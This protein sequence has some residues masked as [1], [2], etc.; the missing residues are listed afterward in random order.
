MSPTLMSETFMS[1]FKFPS[2]YCCYCQQDRALEFICRVL[3]VDVSRLIANV[4]PWFRFLQGAHEQR[5]KACMSFMMQ[6]ADVRWAAAGPWPYWRLKVN[7]RQPRAHRPARTPVS[8]TAQS[9]HSSKSQPAQDTAHSPSKSNNV[10]TADLHCQSPQLSR[11]TLKYQGTPTEAG[12]AKRS[13]QSSSGRTP[14]STA[15]GSAAVNSGGNNAGSSGGQKSEV[16]PPTANSSS[17]DGAGQNAHRAVLITAKRFQRSAVAAPFRPSA[18]HFMPDGQPVC[19]YDWKHQPHRRRY[20]PPRQARWRRRQQSHQQL[21]MQPQHVPY[22]QP[23]QTK[24]SRTSRAC[25]RSR[26]PTGTQ[27]SSLCQPE[28]PT[29]SQ[30]QPRMQPEQEEFRQP[31]QFPQ[32][33]EQRFL[34]QN[35]PHMQPQQEAY[36]RPE[37]SLLQPELIA[38]L[39]KQQCMQPQQETYWQPDHFP[40]QAEQTTLPQNRQC[41]Q[42]QKVHRQQQRKQ[43]RPKGV[44]HSMGGWW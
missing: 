42:P 23:E 21:I 37:Q 16:H 29:F 13:G 36:W 11:D 20:R 14:Q 30:N 17:K 25:E 32:Q 44:Q 41:M 28:Q 7:L 12:S 3:D 2:R 4:Q 31:R 26:R 9:S 24:V 27:S 39:Q 10:A 15:R 19:I 33:A 1:H 5:L 6:W 38:L 34:P 18:I 35:Q 43:Y 40:Q 8:R 22:W